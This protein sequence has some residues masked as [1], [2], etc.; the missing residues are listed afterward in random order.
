MIRQEIIVR[1]NRISLYLMRFTFAMYLSMIAQSILELQLFYNVADEKSGLFMSF[2][3]I[4]GIIFLVF[5]SFLFDRFSKK[6]ILLIA[7]YILSAIVVVMSAMPAITIMYV[8]LI[9]TGCSNGTIGILTNVMIGTQKDSNTT[10]MNIL[11][12][13]FALGAISGPYIAVNIQRNYGIAGMFRL[14]SAFTFIV[15]TIYLVTKRYQTNQTEIPTNKSNAKIKY[16]IGEKHVFI[17]VVKIGLLAFLV[18][19][20]TIIPLTW[21]SGYT[22][23]N[24]GLSRSLGAL[25]ISLYWLGRVA[26]LFLQPKLI[27]QNIFRKTAFNFRNDPSKSRSI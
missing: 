9:L 7:V 15:G 27:K 21:L 3:S 20:S 5:G 26:G 18:G 25:S 23:V 4:G 2:Q 13:F 19:G 11:H 12:L 22:T 8:L 17:R 16:L 24:F 1:T 14:F 10:H 6:K